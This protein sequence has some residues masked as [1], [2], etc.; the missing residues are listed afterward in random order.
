ML[1]RHLC[2][3][4][5]N[6]DRHCDDPD[7][8]NTSSNL[9]DQEGNLPQ[10]SD[11]LCVADQYGNFGVTSDA[12]EEVILY[13][14]QVQTTVDLSATDVNDNVLS[15]LEKALSDELVP[16]LFDGTQCA[17]RRRIK[18]GDHDNVAS[19]PPEE[20]SISQPQLSAEDGSLDTSLTGLQTVPRDLIAPGVEGGTLHPGRS[21]KLWI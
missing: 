19:D 14:Y 13:Q 6:D 10:S 8:E 17:Y 21:V 16:D 9:F 4:D 11:E 5:N 20:Q 18:V 15:V 2:D 3:G 7:E 1:R 12:Y